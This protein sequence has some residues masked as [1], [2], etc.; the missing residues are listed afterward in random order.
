[1]DTDFFYSIN[2]TT[3]LIDVRGW[4]DFFVG[5]RLEFATGDSCPADRRHPRTMCSLQPQ[6][7]QTT[8]LYGH[9]ARLCWAQHPPY[10]GPFP[11]H[12]CVLSLRALLLKLDDGNELMAW[13]ASLRCRTASALTGAAS[14]VVARFTAHFM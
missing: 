8:S 7:W 5:T 3:W 13:T 6:P 9:C 14:L 1:M 4:L 10:L 11:G 2:G 12:V